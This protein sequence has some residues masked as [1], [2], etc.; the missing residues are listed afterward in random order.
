MHEGQQGAV[1]LLHPA[2]RRR[3]DP[4]P[5]P[6]AVRD[7][8]HGT[9]GGPIAASEHRTDR[10]PRKGF[11]GVGLRGLVEALEQP[12][13]RGRFEHSRPPPVR[14]PPLGPSA[15]MPAERSNFV[16]SGQRIE[17]AGPATPDRSTNQ[18][19]RPRLLSILEPSPGRQG[20]GLDRKSTTRHRSNNMPAS[21]AKLRHRARGRASARK[22]ILAGVTA[23]WVRS[24]LLQKES[25]CSC[26]NSFL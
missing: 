3:L 6:G 13:L 2:Q 18:S 16:G 19:P 26:A 14:P 7:L 4:E 1:R 5:R 22:N 10:L 23:G 21:T 17:T 9:V 15:P 20:T 11:E 25:G 8:L 24:H 12:G